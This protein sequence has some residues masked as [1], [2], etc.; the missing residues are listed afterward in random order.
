M[1][2]FLTGMAVALIFSVPAA[3]AQGEPKPPELPALRNAMDSQSGERTLGWLRRA[4]ASRLLP[5]LPSELLAQ[6][7]TVVLQDNLKAEHDAFCDEVTREAWFAR[8]DSYMKGWFAVGAVNAAVAQGDLARLDTLFEYIKLPEPYV[9]FLSYR[10]YEAA[11][12]RVEAYVGD[13]MVNVSANFE[14]WAR[15]N[16]AEN[17]TDSDARS[18][19]A[20]ALYFAGRYEELLELTLAEVDAESVRDIREGDAWAIGMQVRAL[21]ALGRRQEADELMDRLATIPVRQHPWVVN[22]LINRAARLLGQGRW[23]EAL[24]AAD[25]AE[26]AVE[27]YGSPYAE[28]LLGQ[29]RACA[30]AGLGRM[31]D[32]EAAS[33]ILVGNFADAPEVAAY[34]MLCAGR[35]REAARLL[36]N[37]LTDYLTARLARRVQ[38]ERFDMEYVPQATPS[39]MP[40]FT[41]FL[42]AAP[43]LRDAIQREVR[44]LPDR[45]IPHAALMRSE[46]NGEDSN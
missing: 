31:A 20:E 35:E 27:R 22:F 39:G 8:L 26:R 6:A 9:T 23:Q 40:D 11:W 38:D 32:S 19:F 33:N 46:A 16:L 42:L 30:F 37:H 45:L 12:P 3:A 5:R 10:D 7:L 25:K 44:V 21:D 18:T 41:A 36:T 13:H 28:I 1:K 24:D 4:S 15:K 2:A 29:Y 43:S 14:A 17:A 34:G